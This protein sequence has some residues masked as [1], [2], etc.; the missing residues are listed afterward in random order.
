MFCMAGYYTT[1]ELLSKHAYSMA[2]GYMGA[3]SDQQLSSEN[4][5]AITDYINTAPLISK[6]I[7]ISLDIIT[8]FVFITLSILNFTGIL[9]N[10]AFGGSIAMIVI[11]SI[12]LL[13]TICSQSTSDIELPSD[14]EEKF[15]KDKDF[16]HILVELRV[17]NHF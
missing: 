2:E 10:I 13:L 3:S 17:K 1:Y 11:G 14:L 8:S 16:I 15:N 12:N 4:V 5:Q 6:K 9:P 7:F